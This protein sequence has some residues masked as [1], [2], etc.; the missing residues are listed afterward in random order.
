MATGTHDIVHRVLGTANLR[1]SEILRMTPQ[2]V[3]EDLFWLQLR[4]RN[5]SR[6]P[7]P[8]LDVGLA[9]TV[10]AFATRA[11]GRLIPGRSGA[12]VRVLEEAGPLNGMAGTAD[13]AADVAAHAGVGRWLERACLARGARLYSEQAERRDDD[14]TRT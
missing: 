9:R 3:V 10:A 14:R 7:A 5:D 11:V 13:V 12:I 6:F 1:A 8:G 4:E 2:A